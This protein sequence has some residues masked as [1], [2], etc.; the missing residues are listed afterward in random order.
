[1]FREIA[2]FLRNTCATLALQKDFSLAKM[3][4]PVS[5]NIT[6]LKLSFYIVGE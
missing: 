4:E 5:T 1:M 6:F 2:A 3:M